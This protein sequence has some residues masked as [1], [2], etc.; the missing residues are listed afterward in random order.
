MS[1]TTNEV[2]TI[3]GAKPAEDWM[4]RRW[5]PAMGWTYMAICLLDMAVFPVLWSGL[6]AVMG[7]PVTQWDPLT[8]RGAGL[9]HISMGAVLGIAAFG[10]TQEKVAGAS[11]ATTTV[12]V[13]PAP[14][15]TPAPVAA[16]TPVFTPAPAPSFGTPVATSSSGKPMPVQPQQPEL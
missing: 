7:H 3:A 13:A 15:F 9:F 11:T 10:R 16:P 2:E 8:L 14:A 6:Q 12:A 5:R 1:N 4:A